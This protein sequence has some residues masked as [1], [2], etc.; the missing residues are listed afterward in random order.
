MAENVTV[1]RPYAEAAFELARTGKSLGAWSEALG[2]MAAVAADPQMRQCIGDPKL[3]PSQLTLLFLEVVGTGI[4][5]DQRNFVE[6]LVENERLGVLPEIHDVFERLKNGHEGRQDALIT[7][8]FP[9]DSATVTKLVADI[10][11]RFG[12]KLKPTV[13]VDPE[14]IGGVRVAVGDRVIDASVRGKL[15]AM[16][17]A[18]KN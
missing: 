16:A 2:Q 4:S 17:I 12:C 13:Q 6:V 11:P 8:A 3:S 5:A 7:S 18:L 10:E 14:L 9:M 15:D 1:A